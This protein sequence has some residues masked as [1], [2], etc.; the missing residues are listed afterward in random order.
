MTITAR[1][2]AELVRAYPALLPEQIEFALSLSFAELLAELENTR[3]PEH[4]R[5]YSADEN[6]QA[7]NLALELLGEI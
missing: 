4:A 3:N 1:A 5:F 6:T 7:E 2:T